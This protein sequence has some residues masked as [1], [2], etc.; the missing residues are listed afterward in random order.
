MKPLTDDIVVVRGGGDIATGVIQKLHRA[1]LRVAIL[2]TGQPTAI[3][4]T[5]ALCEAVY[6]G[7]A[8]VEDMTARLIP[9]PAGCAAVWAQGDIPVLVD[10]GALMVPALGPDVVVDALLAK[11]NLGT[12]TGMA[13]IVIALG[14]GFAAPTNAHAIV[15]T[16]RGHMLGRVVFQGSALPNT[17][18]PGEIGGK[19]AERVLRAPCAGTV[20]HLRQI[21]D[22]VQAGQAVLSVAGQTVTAPFGGLLRGLIR[23]G[24]PVFAGMKVGDVDP[25]ADSDWHSISDKARCVGGGVL[26][27]YL[28]LRKARA[29][30]KPL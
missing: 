25:R 1:G 16:M 4:R 24:L 7:E 30:G 3:R 14:P 29:D 10:P 18:I 5:V 23:E 26:E 6:D 15:E 21:G 8:R 13:G 19:G 22:A 11:R 9:D 20:K 27:A 2:E 12:H 28:F 17:G